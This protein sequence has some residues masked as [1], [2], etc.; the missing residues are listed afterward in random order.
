M[1]TFTY[2]LK[3]ENIKGAKFW[4]G[5]GVENGNLYYMFSWNNKMVEN[6]E[7]E[8]NNAIWSSSS[9]RKL[10]G[11][12]LFRSDWKMDGYGEDINEMK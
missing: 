1:W 10:K 8:F 9:S 6:L 2:W 4:F 12:E 3:G 5:V 11:W 7:S